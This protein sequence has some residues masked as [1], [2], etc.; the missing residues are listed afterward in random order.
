MSYLVLGWLVPLGYSVLCN[1]QVPRY[2]FFFCGD[3]LCYCTE[4]FGRCAS[5]TGQKFEP[6]PQL[7]NLP[8]IMFV[9]TQIFLL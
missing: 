6:K 1:A 7:R 9:R 2:L 3:L 5:S 8:L 4:A